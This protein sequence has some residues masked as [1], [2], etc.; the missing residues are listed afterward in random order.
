MAYFKIE[1]DNGYPAYNATEYIEID[2]Y[3]DAEMYAEGELHGYLADSLNGVEGYSDEGWESD[4]AEESYYEDGSYTITE[5][6]MDEYMMNEGDECDWCGNYYI[7]SDASHVDVYC[8]TDCQ[9]EAEAELT[10]Q[11]MKDMEANE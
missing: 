9:M 1:Y 2:T 6:D 10:A 8:S 4:E 3:E 5:V 11:E 7:D